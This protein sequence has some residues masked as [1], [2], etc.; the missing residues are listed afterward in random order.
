[1]PSRALTG[2]L[3]GA[4]LWAVRGFRA[5]N[6]PDRGHIRRWPSIALMM[7]GGNMA[8]NQQRHQ[9]SVAS[10]GAMR[11]ENEAARLKLDAERAWLQERG[12]LIV[13]PSGRRRSASCRAKPHNG[14]RSHE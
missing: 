4:A 7:G 3:A 9:R 1:M 14:V 5:P 11:D 8:R 13:C 2:A 12:S 10:L 6:G